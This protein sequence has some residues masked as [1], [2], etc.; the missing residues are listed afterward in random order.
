MVNQH[1]PRLFR[2]AYSMDGD[3]SQK[4]RRASLLKRRLFSRLAIASTLS[5][6]SLVATQTPTLAEGHAQIGLTQAI[7]E[8]GVSFSDAN[9]G[10]FS[11]NH[12]IYVDIIEANEVINIS[13][14]GENDSNDITVEVY[15]TIPNID[16][17][18]LVP[19]TGAEIF[20]DGET[21]TT[22]LTS[23]NVACNSDLDVILTNP[24]KFTASTPGT[25]EIRLFNDTVSGNGLLERVDVTVTSPV[26]STLPGA[27]FDVDPTL[28][29]GRIYAYSW[30]FNADGFGANRAATNDY[31]IKVPGGRPGDNFVWRLDFQNFAGFVY[32][33]LANNLGVDPP[34]EG[35][36]A[37]FVENNG[38]TNITNT[39]T[40]R[41]PLYISF[42]ELVGPR[43]TTPPEVIGF[44][45]TDD[46][47]IDNSISPS[48]GGVQ[49]SGN[50]SFNTDVDGT[51]LIIIDADQ[52]GVYAPSTG[53]IKDVFLF[54][55]TSPGEVLAAW[56]GTDNAGNPLPDGNYT[57]QLQVRL[58]E[59][60]F[61]ASDAETS[62]GGINNG[63]TVFESINNVDSDT[64]VFWD[65]QTLLGDDVPPGQTAT[66]LPGGQLSSSPSARHT[67]GNNTDLGF[68]NRR[69]I[70]TYV[71]G[72]DTVVTSAAIISNDDTPISR[73]YG[74]APDTATTGTGSDG[75]TDNTNYET[76]EVDGGPNHIITADLAIGTVPDA[77]D[78]TQ[79]NAN[80]DDD[81]ASNSDEG[82]ISLPMLTTDDTAYTIS[83]IAVTNTTT[84]P[85]FLVGWIDFDQSG[86]FDPDEQ[87]TA[88][89]A[90]GA[91]TADLEW[92]AT[93][94]NPIPADISAG[95]TY[96]RFRFSSVDGLS[97]TGSAIDGEVEDYRLT[98]T[99]NFPLGSPFICD[100]TFYITV[101]P[102]DTSQQLFD[103]DRSGATFTFNTIGPATDVAGGYPHNFDYNALAYN[104]VDNFIYAYINASDSAT[105]PYAPGN[106]VKIGNDGILHSLGVPTGGTL[107]S[108][109]YAAAILSDGTYVI[110]GGDKFATLDVTTTP[111]TITNS[112]ITVSG[113]NFTD[114][115]VDPRNPVSVSGSEVY[116][117]NQSGSDR[118]VVLDM[119]TF[120][121]SISSSATNPTGFNH[122]SGSQFVDSFGTLYY[123]SNSTD[124]LYR[125]D[126]D[127][128]S[129][130]YGV[131]TEV[132]VAPDGGNHDGVSCLFATAMEK[133]VTDTDNNPITTI[134]AGE[135]VRYVYRIATGNS[136]DLTGVTFE[137]D[138]R[139]VAGG[140][141]IEGTFVPGT[142]TVSNASGTV[143][144]I[145]S[146]QTLQITNLTLPGQ[147]PITPTGEELIITADVMVSDTL[148][149]DTYFNQSTLTDLPVQYPVTIPSD[150]P[151]S[152]PYEDP[153]PIDV[154]APIPSDPN[155]LLVK[156]ITAIN[157]G[158]AGAQIFDGSYVNVGT[159]TDNDNEVNWPGLP[160]AENFGGGTDTVESYLA[161]VS[162]ID[163]VTTVAGVTVDP[164]DEIEYTIPFL[165]NG[166]VA[167]QDVFI[168]DLIPANT[169]FIPD[170]FNG[171]AP[172][173]GDRGIFLSFNNNDVALTNANDGDEIAATGGNNNG[174]GGYYFPPG[175]EPSTALGANV[176]CGGDSNTNGAVVVDL[177]D[178]PQ[179][180]GQGDP[181][182]SYG[183]IRFNVVVR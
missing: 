122:N 83:N 51:Y 75:G 127:S 78:G 45:F 25:Y 133:T 94:T 142:V 103:V 44:K 82:S 117:I 8:Y 114:F 135:V 42:P 47:G 156:R 138:L 128:S 24:L 169:T 134:P 105:G 76:T 120:P 152:A 104:P 171:S 15:E 137:D 40:P 33:L 74:D 36:S 57:A 166:D 84:E 178:L 19:T 48:N 124:R 53:P 130:D 101:G 16:D 11:P 176:N 164:G 145:N 111:P 35:L 159:T 23:S 143:A 113:V 43:P 116:G 56:D 28:T 77:D 64:L 182:N 119:T 125:V 123:R 151:P 165:S 158:L 168:C 173:P 85:A 60:H 38:G 146:D 136:I 72:D 181:L 89:V 96:A 112:N 49:N 70:D 41:F 175:T 58:G 180:I 153:T 109:Y 68:G 177:S 154:S 88:T 21:T 2:S 81:D 31:F 98:V 65:D 26:G 139:S 106:V 121:P 3:R 107:D 148:A 90:A 80:A 34:F 14:C 93:A 167:A 129:P 10:I 118:L 115:A 110:G 79:Q 73:D 174:V 29:Q 5:L 155:V 95:T 100:S 160:T 55:E 39:I 170:A 22:T 132:A 102:S 69:M 61:V 27:N 126:T 71:F 66:T 97:P 9:T 32:E 179:A 13:V 50:F 163:D 140:P 92:S 17:P 18:V 86:S 157:R 12:A 67:W 63:L 87:A 59:F 161:G 20:A 7:F 91:T 1:L 30:A 162:G 54:G 131:A 147:D 4:R 144:L 99:G 149:V 37:N 6:A 62:G 141:P 183:Y 150:Y 52:D 46:A 108:N 172:G